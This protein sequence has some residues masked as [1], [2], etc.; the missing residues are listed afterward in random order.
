[1]L[2]RELIFLFV[3]IIAGNIGMSQT[4]PGGVETTDGSSNLILW[5]DASKEYGTSGNISTLHDYSGSKYHFS[6][7]DGAQIKTSGTNN[8]K[9]IL[10]NGTTNYFERAFT[11]ALNPNNY[12]IISVSKPDST[13]SYKAVISS[14]DGTLRKGYTVYANPSNNFWSF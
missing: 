2:R 13:T 3:F 10:F 5:I 9:S 7:G 6:S 4:G 8:N 11:T 12:T 1:M 14:R